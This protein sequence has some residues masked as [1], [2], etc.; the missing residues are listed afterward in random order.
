M[1]PGETAPEPRRWLDEP[2]NVDKIYYGLIGLCAVVAAADIF[3]HKH[4][5]FEAERLFAAY[6]LYGFVCCV[7]L[8]LAAKELRKLLM[9]DEDYYD[10]GE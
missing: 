8:V 3:Y 6:G 4:V 10:D 9:R 5:H 1:K 2:R 7:G